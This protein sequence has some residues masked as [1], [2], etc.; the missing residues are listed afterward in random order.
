MSRYSNCYLDY[1]SSW[2]GS[3]SKQCLEIFFHTNCKRYLR[4]G[5]WGGWCGSPTVRMRRSWYEPHCT[6]HHKKHQS[7]HLQVGSPPFAIVPRNVAPNSAAD[8]CR[9]YTYHHTGWCIVAYMLWRIRAPR[10]NM[11]IT[12]CFIG[13][14]LELRV[15]TPI[16]AL[17][18]AILCR[19]GHPHIY[20]Q[21][22]FI[23]EAC[24]LSSYRR[25]RCCP[26]LWISAPIST[27]S[28]KHPAPHNR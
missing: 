8:R 13:N 26:M 27:L 3:S 9:I 7:S 2:C 22:P 28:K 20:I 5:G 16:W 14:G 15:P 4:W 11:Q 21:H 6:L 24:M 18:D 12:K 1:A 10:L 25:C 17:L 19:Y 23:R